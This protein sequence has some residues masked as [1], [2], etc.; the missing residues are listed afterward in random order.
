M[1]EKAQ[2]S[3]VPRVNMESLIT[4]NQHQST[5]ETKTST[6]SQVL[7]TQSRTRL[8]L[9]LTQPVLPKA[10]PLLNRNR[11]TKLAGI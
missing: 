2:Q 1:L 4:P 9:K 6:K 8:M 11:M 3:R 7:K 5:T 10:D